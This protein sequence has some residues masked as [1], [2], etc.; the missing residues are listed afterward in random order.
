LSGGG[1][2]KICFFSLVFNKKTKD[3]RLKEIKSF[4]VN[5]DV[6]YVKFSPCGTFYAFALLDNSIRINFCDSD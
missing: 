4:E 2:K 3:I 6:Q 1:D 5:D